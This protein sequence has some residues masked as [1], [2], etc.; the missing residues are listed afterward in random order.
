MPTMTQTPSIDLPRL[1]ND[2]R[3]ATDA[4]RAQKAILHEPGQPRVSWKT[5]AELRR[6]KNQATRLCQ[7]RAHCRGRIHILGM[8][9]ELQAEQV[10]MLT[11]YYAPVAQSARAPGLMPQEVASSSLAG[12]NRST[13]GASDQPTP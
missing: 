11:A 1:R 10:S 2:M 3:V 8:A 9:L 12:R 4:L 13:D 6:L 7:L 5:W